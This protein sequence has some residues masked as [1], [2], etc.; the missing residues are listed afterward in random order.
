MDGPLTCTIDEEFGVA[1]GLPGPIEQFFIE[2]A[3]KK[4]HYLHKY[5][6]PRCMSFAYSVYLRGEWVGCLVFGRPQAGRLFKGP[7]TYGGLDDVDSGRAKY[8]RWEILNLSRVWLSP[9]VQRGGEHCRAGS[10]PG[11]VDRKGVFRSALASAVIRAAIERIRVDYLLMFPPVFF[12]KWH[13]RA[14]LSYCDT[15]LHRGT[16]YRSSGFGL[17]SCNRDGIE[18]YSFEGV[19]PLGEDDEMAIRLAGKHHPRSIKKRNAAGVSLPPGFL[20]GGPR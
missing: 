15:R 5:P 6:D 17:A 2:D 9:S 16:I 3:I 1:L 11:F 14:V 18:T 10:L 8:C 4:F 13:I 20:F 7:L 12:K 19:S